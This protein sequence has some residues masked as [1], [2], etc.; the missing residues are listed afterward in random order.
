[1]SVNHADKVVALIPARSGSQRVPGKN[2][3][4]LGGHPL[5]AYTIAAARQSE[6]FDAVIVSTDSADYA[7]LAEYYGAEVPFIRPAELAG[8]T[9]PDIDWVRHALQ[10][11]TEKGRHFDCFSILRPT[12]PF[13]T[14]ATIQRA[15]RMLPP[16]P[17]PIR[18]ARWKSVRNILARCG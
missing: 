18:C 17:P 16:I 7:R 15:W 1:M 14:A 3:R 8:A 2:V 4:R 12:S 13:R 6:V 9:S 11:L 5:L 10:S